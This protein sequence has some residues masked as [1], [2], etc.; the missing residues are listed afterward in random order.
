MFKKIILIIISAI[1]LIFIVGCSKQTCLEACNEKGFTNAQCVQAGSIVSMKDVDKDRM[2][3]N[4]TYT[5]KFEAWT[6]VIEGK[7]FPYELEKFSDCKFK[8]SFP[9]TFSIGPGGKICCCS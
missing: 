8:K 3:L 7:K 2:L 9:N 6:P 4:S 5:C 1:I